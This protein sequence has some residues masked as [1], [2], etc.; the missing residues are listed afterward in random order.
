M[1]PRVAPEGSGELD[2]DEMKQIIRKIGRVSTRE[3]TD[4]ELKVVYHMIDMD[5]GGTVSGDEFEDFL[6]NADEAGKRSIAS[7][8]RR[9]TLAP[10][11]VRARADSPDRASPFVAPPPFRAPPP[12]ASFNDI[13]RQQRSAPVPTW[14]P[15]LSSREALYKP[16]WDN[17]CLLIRRTRSASGMLCSLTLLR[18]LTE[19]LMLRCP[20]FSR[21]WTKPWLR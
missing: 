7:P 12:R 16:V 5:G 3:V 8:S 15:G 21:P 13:V 20:R 9:Q 17:G 11:E 6:G 18:F 4:M 10:L 14:A 19:P 2:F 1:P